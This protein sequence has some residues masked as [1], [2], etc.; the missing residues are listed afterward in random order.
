MA[1]GFGNIRKLKSGN[2]QVRYTAPDG[3]R[4]SAPHTFKQK[5]FASAFLAR[6]KTLIDSGNWTP[7]HVRKAKVE[8]SGVTVDEYFERV[9]KRRATRA[10]KPLAATTVDLYRKQYRL[11]IADTFGAMPV[12]DV[13]KTVVAAW[14]D[15]PTDKLSQKGK[16]YEMM[17]S[18]FK[19]AVDDELITKNPWAVA[20]AG[21]PAPKAKGVV[22][23]PQE[24][25]AYL[26]AVKPHYRLM[27][28]LSALSGL[29]S[30]EVRGLRVCDI[31]LEQQTLSVNVAVTRHKSEDGGYTYK[32][33]A[34][35]T[36]A[37]IRTLAIPS[38]CLEPLKQV[39]ERRKT[40]G[41]EAL[42]FPARDGVTPMNSSTLNDAHNG[43]KAASGHWDLKLHDLRR[44]AATLSAQEGATIAELMRMLG[45]TTPTVA[46][47]YQ[48]ATDERERLRASRVDER[49]AQAWE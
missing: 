38:M 42:L 6:E 29:R 41:D 30:G 33:A 20:G 15:E 4:Y 21:K 32:L 13:T 24:L 2:Y 45:H 28:M 22:L 8:A 7:P 3:E 47:I 14:W 34:P 27:M 9:L 39:V 1:G 43:A 12:K 26:E 44:T 23:S 19:D 18:V 36:Q 40:F 49:I 17:R 11:E 16:A 48:R 25:K 37:G 31:D 5:G 35:K 46:M 10:R